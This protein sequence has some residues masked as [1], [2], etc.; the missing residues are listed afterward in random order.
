MHSFRASKE[1][2][3][4][5]VGIVFRNI[6][7]LLSAPLVWYLIHCLG[8]GAHCLGPREMMDWWGGS[9]YLGFDPGTTA[10][11]NMMSLGL[12][13][14]QKVSGRMIKR[15]K[16]FPTLVPGATT[17]GK[18]VF[19]HHWV[20]LGVPL[21][22]KHVQED[23]QAWEIYPPS[24]LGLAY[25]IMTKDAGNTPKNAGKMPQKILNIYIYSHTCQKRP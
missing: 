7:V 1:A 22:S 11:V 14:H 16:H 2:T 20:P 6:I 12:P 3:F 15:G 24:R 4:I 19:C 23:D 5:N 18:M 10:M 17:V 8:P 9:H 25:I 21:P 13:S